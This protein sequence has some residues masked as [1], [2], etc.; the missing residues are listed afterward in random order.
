MKGEFDSMKASW[1]AS[2][3]LA[4]EAMPLVVVCALEILEGRLNSKQC[5]Q[6]DLVIYATVILEKEGNIRHGNIA[7]RLFPFHM[8]QRL[9]IF[10]RL[11]RKSPM[12]KTISSEKSMSM[13]IVL[14]MLKVPCRMSAPYVGGST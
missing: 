6:V 1:Q 4:W 2:T 13:G 10:R 12:Q 5:F 9:R 3:T 14:P 7:M 8:I 11:M